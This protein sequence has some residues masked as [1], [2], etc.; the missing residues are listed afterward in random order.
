MNKKII[1]AL[2]IFFAF[3]AQS[4]FAN[5]VSNL[6]D[7][8]FLTYSEIYSLLTTIRPEPGAVDKLGILLNTVFSST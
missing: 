2:L 6:S 5:Y 7:S 8:D 3:L 4:S 1:A